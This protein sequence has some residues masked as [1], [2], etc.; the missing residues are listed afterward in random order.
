[1]S[2]NLSYAAVVIGTLSGNIVSKI[3]F[4]EKCIQYWTTEGE[5]EMFGGVKVTTVRITTFLH[6]IIRELEI[7]KVT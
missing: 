4:Q 5:S 6:Y 7:S 2:Q 3:S 1:M